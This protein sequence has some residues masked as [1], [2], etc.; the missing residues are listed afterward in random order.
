LVQFLL[1]L[2]EKKIKTHF[3]L[4]SLTLS[5]SLLPFRSLRLNLKSE[6][7]RDSKDSEKKADNATIGVGLVRQRRPFMLSFIKKSI[8]TT[9]SAAADGIATATTGSTATVDQIEP[10][11]EAT[12]HEIELIRWKETVYD[13]IKAR[14]MTHRSRAGLIFNGLQFDFR[15]S[16][17]PRS[18]TH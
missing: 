1:Q 14:A 10:G 4:L 12:A 16:A 2:P 3:D 9:S 6:D 7:Q 18:Q 11:I 8:T 5:L 13:I 17:I 15:T